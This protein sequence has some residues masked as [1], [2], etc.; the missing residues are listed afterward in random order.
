MSSCMPYT[1]VGISGDP[2]SGKT[3]LVQVLRAQLGWKVLSIGELFRSKFEVW[4]SNTPLQ[5]SHENFEYWWANIVAGAEIR[6]VNREAAARI[7]QENLILDSRYVAVNAR[8]L[9]QV[10]RV[11]LTAPIEVRAQR[12]I[13]AGKYSN[14]SLRGSGGVMDI[15]H[16]RGRDEYQRG[17]SLF[18]IDY[19]NPHDYHLVLNTGL[20]TP[21]Q[22]VAQVCTLLQQ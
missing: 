18:N 17:N 1:A 12:A 11:F 6:E 8:G 15:L 9:P 3:S 13:T 7:A 4:K 14:L 21:E 20:L 22:E 5:A 2:C 19:R 10:A 16:Q